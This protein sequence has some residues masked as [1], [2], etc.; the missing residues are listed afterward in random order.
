[1]SPSR[2]PFQSTR[3]RS[4]GFIDHPKESGRKDP[5]RSCLQ[6]D[7]DGTGAVRILFENETQFAQSHSS[8]KF[9]EVTGSH[10]AH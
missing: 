7:F 6:E 8:D 2:R 3:T 4:P 10:E 5:R 1:M 9:A